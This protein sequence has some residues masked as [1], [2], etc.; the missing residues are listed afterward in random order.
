MTLTATERRALGVCYDCGVSVPSGQTR[1]N[2][3]ACLNAQTLRRQR[4]SRKST[5]LFALG[6]KCIRCGVTDSRVLEIDHINGDGWK[7]RGKNFRWQTYLYNS[8]GTLRNAMENLDRFQLLCANCH[9]IK[10]EEDS[11]W[12]PRRWGEECH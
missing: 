7:E 4:A 1:C 12:L 11:E 5:L 8:P 9:A 6:G 10:T 2:K 3:H